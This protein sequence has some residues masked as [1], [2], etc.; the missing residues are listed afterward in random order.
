MALSCLW[1]SARE[2]GTPTFEIAVGDIYAQTYPRVDDNGRRAAV[3]KVY[4]DD[5]ITEVR[6]N[7]LGNIIDN[8]ME[9]I[10]YLTHDSKNVEI[11]FRNHYPVKV[12]FNDY[13]IPQLG[14]GMTYIL[15][16]PSDGYTQ[17]NQIRESHPDQSPISV[18]AEQ[19][20]PVTN[21]TDKILEEINTAYNNNEYKKVFD[22]AIQ[23]LENPTA[24]SYLGSLYYNGDFVKQDYTEA[25]KLFTRAAEAG[26]SDAMNYLGVMYAK[27]NGISND[28]IEAVRWFK[29]SAESGNKYAMQN[30]GMM[31][32]NGDG[33]E[34]D[35]LEAIKWY[36]KAIALGNED[37]CFNLG[38]MYKEGKG[39]PQDYSEAVKLL[40]KAADLGN[41]SA[42]NYLGMMYNN[43]LG[44]LQDSSEAV[45]WYRKGADLG[46]D[47]AMLNL[48][49]CYFY[50]RGVSTD[51]SEALKWSHKALECGNIF[52]IKMLDELEEVGY[53]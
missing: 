47:D 18:H 17:S 35:Y 44:V 24:Q 34:R 11:L 16:F 28:D 41:T 8:G 3:L 38:L 7:I 26:D 20:K 31:Y 4:V 52:A 50:G 2:Y 49:T 5:E 15:K 36:R 39:V 21:S 12:I 13:L 53:K 6:G 14:G 23:I 46:D 10:L 48:A 27:G 29:K 22:L 30:I 43:G 37:A 33:V 1:I 51:Y 25:F 42:M 9:K 32:E 45:K 19:Q 40:Q